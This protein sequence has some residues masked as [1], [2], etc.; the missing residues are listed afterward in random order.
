MKIEVDPQKI[1]TKAKEKNDENWK[2]RSFLKMYG[3]RKS[4]DKIV[5][6]IAKEIAAK[7]DCTECGNCCQVCHPVLQNKD[8][9][10]LSRAISLSKND[11]K[12]KYTCK[13]E[14][15]DLVFSTKPCPF[16]ENNKCLHYDSRPGDCVSYPHLH[17]RDFTSRLFGVIGNIAICPIVYNVYERLKLEFPDWQR[18]SRF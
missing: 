16:W 7:I 17:K 5:Q 1:A 12:T 6:R 10:T 11:F 13:D 2:F 15:G 9:E 4:I 14:D 8:I 3:G 18:K